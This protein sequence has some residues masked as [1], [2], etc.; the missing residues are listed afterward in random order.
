MNEAELSSYGMPDILLVKNQF[1]NFLVDATMVV[2]HTRH[3]LRAAL[4]DEA[5][6]Q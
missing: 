5:V 4:H 3:I 2:A 6:S 1:I